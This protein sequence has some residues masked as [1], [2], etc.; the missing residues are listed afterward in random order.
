MTIIPDEVILLGFCSVALN[1]DTDSLDLPQLRPFIILIAV[2]DLGLT[3]QIGRENRGRSL[4][5]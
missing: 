4:L 1:S 5:E 2:E 3:F